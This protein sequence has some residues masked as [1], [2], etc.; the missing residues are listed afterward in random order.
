[1]SAPPLPGWPF[2]ESPFHEGERAVQRRLGVDVKLETAGRKVIRNAMPE[3]YRQFFEQLPFLLVG[4]IDAEGQPWASVLAGRPGFLH[5]PTPQQLDIR[6]QLLHADPLRHTL[7]EGAAIGVL[8][9]EPHT[10][11]RNRMNGTVIVTA[12]RSGSTK[13]GSAP[14]FLMTL[15][16]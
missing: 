13:R 12:P 7:S 10:R 2:A 15:K 11:R 6:A 9:I 16:K 8:G 1:M 3:Q 4:S 14:R 5:A